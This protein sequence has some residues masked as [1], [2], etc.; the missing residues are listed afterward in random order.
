LNFYCLGGEGSAVGEAH[1]PPPPPPHRTGQMTVG[2]STHLYS[3]PALGL[4]KPVR[5]AKISGLITR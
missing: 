4:A 1:P 5:G 3:P 2:G